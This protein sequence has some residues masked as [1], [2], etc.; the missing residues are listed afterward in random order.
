[1]DVVIGTQL[2]GQRKIS[3]VLIPEQETL[4]VSN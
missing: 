2:V 3:D 1:M 4:H